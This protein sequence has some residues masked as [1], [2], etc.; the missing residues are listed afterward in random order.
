MLVVEEHMV[1]AI[2]MSYNKHSIN[3]YDSS[4]CLATKPMLFNFAEEYIHTSFQ[5]SKTIQWVSF[6]AQATIKQYSMLGNIT[7]CGEWKEEVVSEN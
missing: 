1:K 6:I 5:K 3:W 2:K 4:G 7:D